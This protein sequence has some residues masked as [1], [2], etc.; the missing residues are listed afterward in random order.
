MK[1]IVFIGAGNLATHLA[2]ELKKKQFDIVQIY[3]RTF[4]SANKLALQIKAKASNNIEELILDADIYIFSVKDSILPE[5]ID[6]LPKNKGLLLHTAGSMSI[7]VFKDASSRYGVIYPFQT[8]SKNR[9]VDFETVPFFIEGN[10]QTEENNIKSLVNT[11]SKRVYHLS[12]EKRKSVHLSGVFACNFTNYMYT[13]AENILSK[14]NIPFEVLLP[15]IDETA[16]KVHTMSTKEAQTGPAVRYD[17][18]VI[19]KHLALIEDSDI[20]ELYQ[21][22]S[23]NIYKTN[24][25]Q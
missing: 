16:L 2:I 23:K 25:E 20:R 17:I 22:I 1:K 24:N 7:D 14:E 3:S 10:N 4:E 18:N 8:F 13:L 11:L 9:S 12:S 21:Q 6:K 15:L 19:E 5:L